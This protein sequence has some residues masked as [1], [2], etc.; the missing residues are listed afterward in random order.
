[1]TREDL[2]RIVA[3]VWEI[4]QAGQVRGA[5]YFA[6]PG[7]EESV[8]LGSMDL[9]TSEMGVVIYRIITSRGF[10]V[11]QICRAVMELDKEQRRKG[12]QMA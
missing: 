5:T 9:T 11:Q 10:D 12:E 8:V 7:L 4:L 6:S 3:P 2:D 1:M